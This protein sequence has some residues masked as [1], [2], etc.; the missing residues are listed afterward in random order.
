MR[1][2][3]IKA[4][5]EEQRTPLPVVVRPDGSLLDVHGVLSAYMK[6]GGVGATV[7]PT[8]ALRLAVGGTRFADLLARAEEV[9]RG[10][11]ALDEFL[12][13][14]DTTLLAPLRPNRILAIGRNYAEHAQE[15]GNTVGEEPIVFLKANQCVVGPG[16][17][18]V[19][20]EWVGRVDYEAELL[21][22]LGKGG[23]N[24]PEADALGLVA[25]YTVFNDVTAREIQK[26]LQAKKHPWFLGKSMDT[27]GPTGPYLVTA[28]EVP[29]PH[30][31]RVSLTVNGET[32]QDGRTSA[33][34]FRIPALIAF[35]SKYM[36][37][38]P[39]DVIATG[40][41]PGVGP[42]A[43]GDVVEASVEGLGTLRNPVVS[44]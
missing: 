42:I 18:I 5:R 20:P 38:E 2:A 29:D 6:R 44:G 39:G 41:P 3:L 22:V 33:M 15:L 17:P 9:L 23:Q 13:P 25:G 21:V 1:F 12:R 34:V 19:I 37:L 36:A 14:A 40:T 35:L 8:S 27:F 11:G 4:A 24:V 32:R 7:F 43:P 31:L 16:E 28:D 10:D 26:G 30:D